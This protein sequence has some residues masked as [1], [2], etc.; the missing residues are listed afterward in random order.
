MD[1]YGVVPN[2][3]TVVLMVVLTGIEP[4]LSDWESGVLTP[5]RKNHEYILKN[6]I[7]NSI[8][9]YFSSPPPSLN[10]YSYTH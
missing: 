1:D 5:R 7:K 8:V 3:L 6:K 2:Y 10:Y 9:L 4:V